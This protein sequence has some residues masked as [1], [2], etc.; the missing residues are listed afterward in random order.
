MFLLDFVN[1][2]RNFQ[3]YFQIVPA[4]DEALQQT[5]FRIR[6]KV[7]CEELGFEPLRDNGMETDG[8]DVHS[9]HI[10]IRSVTTG[11]Y[12]GCIRL[13][14]PDPARPAQLLPF[15]QTCAG[16]L[17][18]SLIDP[19]ALPRHAIAEVS[20]LAVLAAYR[21]R[22]GE[23]HS[24]FPGSQRDFGSHTQPRFPYLTA[25]LYLG[26]IATAAHHGIDTLFTLTEPR[27]ARHLA[28][29]GVKVRQ[30]GG[31]VEHRGRRVPSMLDTQGV[32]NGL[33][34]FVRPLYAV[35]EAEVER[36]Y[37]ESGA[38]NC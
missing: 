19:A 27:L 32:I 8:Y 22:K 17:D 34:F 21:R 10:L 28:A 5:A 36:A 26:M 13:A 30:I 9:L 11:E 12:V 38:V 16:T 18:R 31:G 7:Y 4:V 33:S 15:E 37:A 29:L 3:K 35:I 24:A 1:L 23:S 2:G 20:R 14:R 25:G 6:H